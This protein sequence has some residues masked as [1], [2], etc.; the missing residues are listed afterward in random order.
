[1]HAAFTALDSAFHVPWLSIANATL[2]GPQLGA[3]L[4]SA[5]PLGL[6]PAEA[7][8]AQ[9]IVGAAAAAAPGHAAECWAV[10][11][12]LQLTLGFIVPVVLHAEREAAEF[13]AFW[14]RHSGRVQPGWCATLYLHS[15][16]VEGQRGGGGVE[17]REGEYGVLRRVR[18]LVAGYFL[19][20]PLWDILTIM[21]RR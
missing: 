17:M 18:L 1:M 9:A 21:S 11:A 7:M 2:A 20:L 6:V 13:R 14:R 3:E 10:V 4:D 8:P 12:M 15:A 16:A 5:A 19:L